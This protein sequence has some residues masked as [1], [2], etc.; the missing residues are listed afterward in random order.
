MGQH[1]SK[2]I[3]MVKELTIYGFYSEDDRIFAQDYPNL[4]I[5]KLCNITYDILKNN[6]F[7]K[8][9]SNI[10]FIEEINIYNSNDIKMLN[11]YNNLKKLKAEYSDI[12]DLPKINTLE[13][14]YIK[15]CYHIVP[16]P[17]YPNLK[18]LT[19]ENLKIK[20]IPYLPNLIELIIKDC[21]HINSI[22][23]YPNLIEL[24][25]K[26]C[27]YIKSIPYYPKLKYLSCSK[28]IKS[29]M[30]NPLLHVS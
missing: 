20:S 13:V 26:D 12:I 4:K 22:P 30:I 23:Y 29:V 2:N 19:I 10:S 15:A 14:L 17:Y 7:K 18:K 9:I 1:Q 5:L 6:N 27:Y 11:Y 16:I 8:L 3:S 28:Y 21:Y 25:I 24:I